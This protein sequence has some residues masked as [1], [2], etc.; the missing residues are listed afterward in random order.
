MSKSTQEQLG[1]PPVNGLTVRSDFDGG[2]LR[3]ISAP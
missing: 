2:A 3:R 1:F